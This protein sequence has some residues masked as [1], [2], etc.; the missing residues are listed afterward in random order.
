NEMLQSRTHW[1]I[2]QAND[3]KVNYLINELNVTPLVAKLLVNRGIE[4]I[5]KAKSFLF[6]DGDLYDP[7]LLED[8]HIAVE[9][10]NQAIRNEEKI[11][12]YGDYDA[13][14]VTSTYVL[15]STL[16]SLGAH[17]DYYIPNRFTEG[18]GPN[19][20]AFRFLKD[21]GTDLIIT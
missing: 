12:V 4:T 17:A 14:G 20:E 8:M 9:R 1:K 18:Y 16:R 15:L 13:D 11:T 2:R 5:D 7:F 3:E 10:I 6:N 21:Q 19:E